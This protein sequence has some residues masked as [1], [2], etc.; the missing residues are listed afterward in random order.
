MMNIPL[1]ILAVTAK[2]CLLLSLININ[3]E[4]LCMEHIDRVEK[5]V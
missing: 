4:V 2:I 5:G 1:A 3:T